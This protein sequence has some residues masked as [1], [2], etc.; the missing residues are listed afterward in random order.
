MKF[1]RAE[2]Y[3]RSLFPE[4]YVLIIDA[5]L[6]LRFFDHLVKNGTKKQGSVIL[7]GLSGLDE[8]RIQ[9]KIQIGG[10]VKAQ[11]QVILYDLFLYQGGI[12]I[13]QFP[14]VYQFELLTG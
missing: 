11:P 8:L 1:F 7:I 13:L 9:A 2:V 14:I 12:K 3:F 5:D 10:L 6:S 4:T